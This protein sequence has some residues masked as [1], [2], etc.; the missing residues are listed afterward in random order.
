[1]TIYFVI[2]FYTLLGEK[3]MNAYL[4]LS[5]IFHS[6]SLLFLPYYYKRILNIKIRVLEMISIMLF[7]LI[8]YFNV[9]LFKDMALINILFVFIFFLILYKKE[10]FK[11]F[12]VYLLVY[13]SN[14]SL[15]LIFTHDVYLYHCLVFLNT[16]RAFF[17]IFLDF[18]NIVLIEIIFLSIKS[19][20]LLKN[21]RLKVGI[22]IEGKVKKL[23]AYVDSGNTL[24][25]D[26]L[27]VI[28]IKDNYFIKDRYERMLVRG[29]GS[30]ECRYFKSS[31]YYKGKKANVIC[32]SGGKRG[33]KGCDCLLNIHLLEE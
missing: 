27:P 16:P 22:E 1:M 4:D 10:F 24:I 23:N 14:I 17:Y 18:L 8:L 19:I 26:N 31:I 9:F 32:A 11:R 33:F 29:I 30:R 13:Y 20:K 7:G 6:I 3:K 5:F 12:I 25:V 21:Y 28:F 2:F 15:I